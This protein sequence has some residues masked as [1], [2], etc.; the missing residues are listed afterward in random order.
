[1]KTNRD[2]SCGNRDGVPIHG[3]PSHFQ[4]TAIVAFLDLLGFSEI[5]LN[6]WSTTP[7]NPFD[8]LLSIRNAGMTEGVSVGT[9]ADD[10][11]GASRR[12]PS[13]VARVH[14]L[15]D[16]IVASVAI[17][18]NAPITDFLN[19]LLSASI[20]A[21]WIAAQALNDG[22][23]LRGGIEI[24]P[25]YWSP[26]DIVGPALVMSA[27]LESRVA[28]TARVILGPNLIHNLTMVNHPRIYEMYAS[29][30]LAK[31][32][33]GLIGLSPNF[34]LS[35]SP[36]PLPRIR[37]IQADTPAKFQPKYQVLIDSIARGKQ[38]PPTY[39]ELSKGIEMVIERCKPLH[40]IPDG[41]NR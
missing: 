12:L 29:G 26:S 33:D 20:R 1:M 22:F 17:G 2:P 39:D 16:S 10:E 15:S 41:D 14:M 24:G 19:A 3:A 35:K 23:I 32:D 37:R 36:D 27:H 18:D 6:N 21:S 40:V 5:V 34:V 8:R 13:Y 7:P 31:F 11:H 25:I 30:I 28:K 4:G 9:V 38:N